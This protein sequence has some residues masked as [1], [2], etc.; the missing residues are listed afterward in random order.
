MTT[1]TITGVELTKKGIS[2]LKRDL[3]RTSVLSNRMGRALRDDARRRITTQGD[4]S[5]APMS[6]WTAA[7]TGRKK[8]L[9]SERPKITFKLIGGRLVVGHDSGAGWSLQDHERGFTTPPEVPATIALKRPK[10]LGI[11][12][13]EIHIRRA[14]ESVTPAR[15]VFATEAETVKI[16]KPIVIKWVNDILRRAKAVK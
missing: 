5:W 1:L 11:S 7:R 15:R 9:I 6:K 16:A 13:S 4:G 3:G 10:I 8:L 2:K 12:T 14:K